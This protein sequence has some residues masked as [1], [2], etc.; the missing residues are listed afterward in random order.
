MRHSFSLAIAVT[1]FL[2]ACG[3]AEFGSD[4]TTN[5]KTLGEAGG[6]VAQG[7]GNEAASAL[8]QPSLEEFLAMLN[9]SPET[10]AEVVNDN[11]CCLRHGQGHGI[12]VCVPGDK[13]K[14][15]NLDPVAFRG[16]DVCITPELLAANKDLFKGATIG[17]CQ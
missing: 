5:Q 13:T 9:S 16:N 12:S 1:L 10:A 11:E 2:T 7:A 6:T 14:I 4:G 15:A 3:P 17:E 8:N